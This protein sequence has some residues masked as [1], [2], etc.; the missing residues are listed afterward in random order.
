[1]ALPP[2]ANCVVTLVSLGPAVS[3][4]SCA[5]I[6]SWMVLHQ[7]LSLAPNPRMLFM[8]SPLGAAFHPRVHRSCPALSAR[9]GRQVVRR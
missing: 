1:M 8:W 7:S 6:H 4:G 2:G 5:S 3:A 9:S